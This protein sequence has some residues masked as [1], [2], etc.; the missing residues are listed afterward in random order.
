M[1][2]MAEKLGLDPVELRLKNYARLEDG[3]QD[4]KVPFSSNGMEE[5]IR[6]AA[7]AFGWG[8]RWQKPG[9]SP[10]PVK[11]GLGMAI[12]S[13]PHGAIGA[14]ATGTV[15][16]NSDGTVNV[17]VGT[18]DIGGGQK[19][20]MAMIA[21][22]ELGIPL[23]AVS[24]TSA[25]TEATLNTLSTGGSRQTI[26]TGGAVKLAAAEVKKQ[27]LELAAKELKTGPETLEMRDGG[28]Y[29]LGSDKGMPITE[30]LKK[31]PAT[32]T[33][34]GTRTPP[35]NMITH[36]FAAHFVEVEV[37]TLS[38][39]VRVVKLVA[40][41]DVGKAISQLG[42]ENQIDGGSIQGMG[43]GL[44][45][46]LITDKGTGIIV[47]PNLV[48]YKLFTMKDIPEIEPVIVEPIDPLGPFGA[49]GLG[50]PPYSVPAP[51]IAN[52]IYNAIGVRFTETPINIRPVLDGL[53]K[54]AKR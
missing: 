35:P 50:E 47:N 1:D 39:K 29:P 51:A 12:H 48:D 18:A 5:C 40:A 13:C 54:L 10:G 20:V 44:T 30:V 52:A 49:K 28:I 26:G 3:D 46:D 42:V 33:G 27:L 21:A 36:C 38:G 16:L 4:R 22:E 17:F 6:K 23:D 31:A 37:D 41:H 34:R 43:F 2:I 45:E 14:F 15:K 32:L 8:Q 53:K 7:E 11:K 19:S 24:V 25:D 9:A